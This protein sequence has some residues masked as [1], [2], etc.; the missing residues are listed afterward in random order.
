MSRTSIGSHHRWHVS[1]QGSCTLPSFYSK[2]NNRPQAPQRFWLPSHTRTLDPGTS[3][4]YPPS[5]SSSSFFEPISFPFSSFPISYFSV[6]HVIHCTTSTTISHHL[7]TSL[8]FFLLDAYSAYFSCTWT[9]RSDSLRGYVWGIRRSHAQG[10]H[11]HQC[12]IR[13]RCVRTYVQY[14]TLCCPSAVY[15]EKS[16]STCHLMPAHVYVPSISQSTV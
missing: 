16:S 5:S 13:N 7:F 8:H 3:H 12:R 6:S 14:S 15:E 10:W 2:A 9:W 1:F 11:R 4:P